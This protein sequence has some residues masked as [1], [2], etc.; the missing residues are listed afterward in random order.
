[1]LVAPEYVDEDEWTQV[2]DDI[3]RFQL[4]DKCLPFVP[5]S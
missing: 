2:I 4:S 1:M 3:D 5:L